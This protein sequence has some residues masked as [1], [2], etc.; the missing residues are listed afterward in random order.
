MTD[1]LTLTE[2]LCA[3]PS[4]GGSETALADLVEAQLRERA[5]NLEVVR[6]GA[7]IVARTLRGADVRVVLGGI[8]PP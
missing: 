6:S 7:N 5:P 4:V 3:V 1:L 2:Q 8:R